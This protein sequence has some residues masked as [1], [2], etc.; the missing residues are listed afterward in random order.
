MGRAEMSAEIFE[1]INP[2][3]PRTNGEQYL[4]D[5]FKNSPRFKNW[6]IFEQPHIN[7]M[8]PDFVLLH[9]QR[10]IIIV[11]VKDW[12]VNSDVYV[13]GGYVKGTDGQ[14]H[15]KNPIKQVENYKNNILKNELSNSVY[16]AESY[17]N[18]YGCIETVV[19][20]HGISKIKAK[21]FCQGNH[22]YTKIWTNEDIEVIANVQ[23]ELDPSI[24]T[25]ALSKNTSKFNSDG[26]LEKLVNELLNHLQYADY[27]YE[28]RQRVILTPEQ[29]KPL[30]ELKVG[31]I[32]RWS[33]VAGSG[34]SLILSEKAV[35]ALKENYRVL[36]LTYN[37]TLRHYL[38]DLCSQQFGP[39]TYDGERKKLRQELTIIHFHDFLK[40][41]MTEHEIEF[42]SDDDSFKDN[43]FTN[44]SLNAINTYLANYQKKNHFNYDFILIDEGQDFKGDWVRFIKN[45][46]TGSGEL[47]IVYDKA[48][49]IFNNGLW[50]E[51]AGQIRD[52]GFRGRPG[53]LRYSHRIPGNMVKKIQIIRRHLQIIGVDIL[54]PENEQTNLFQTSYWFNY[55]AST[56]KEKLFQLDYH[57][58]ELRKSNKME[59]ITIL[60][61][62][63]N[64]G[65]EVVEYFENKGYRTS[66]VY[67]LQRE[68]NRKRRRNEKWKFQGGTGRL[69]ICSYHSYKGWETPNVILILDSPTTNYLNGYISYTVANQQQVKDALFIS[70]SRVKGK[71]TTGE[72]SYICLNYLA[73]Y[74]NLKL[75]F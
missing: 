15:K 70:M 13:N 17:H 5:V 48:Q 19:Y 66:H 8:K 60:T 67:D 32:R 58:N 42:D 54:I 38:R 16:L 61:T 28:R 27:N 68:K 6:V 46:F 50:I 56:I 18:Y 62:N 53:I 21:E 40:V 35:T 51:D 26:L 7:S 63:E 11:E 10:G 29:K 44:R 65:A 47:F 36:I 23:N 25:F 45:F 41:F 57:V 9:P 37:I 33:G 14:L 69:K 2:N 30:D 24:Y 74:N 75:L 55:S 4:I 22:T 72:Y 73:E 64:T 49:D 31:S 20:F 12:N 3:D 71:A 43:D 59:D 39:N 34:K 1:N 52:I